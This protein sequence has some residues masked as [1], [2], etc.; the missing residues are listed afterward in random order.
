MKTIHVF[1][2]LLTTMLFTSCSNSSLDVV[3]PYLYTFH[4][5][6]VDAEN[7]NVLED[8]DANFL[9]ASFSVAP[10]SKE[11]VEAFGVKSVKIGDE[12]YLEVGVASNPSKRL[13]SIDF[14]LISEEIFNDDEN[15]QVKTVWKWENRVDNTPFEIILG[16]RN[17]NSK[18]VTSSFKYFIVE[19]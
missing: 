7:D 8:L 15:H 18:V 16:D 14:N 2:L 4:L 13:E 5:K 17:L 19:L 11:E 3:P 10:S 1:A 12:L 6:F 9:A